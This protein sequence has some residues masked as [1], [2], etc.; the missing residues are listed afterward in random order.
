MCLSCD[1]NLFKILVIN[2][3]ATWIVIFV[4]VFELI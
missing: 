4:K 3:R 2:F 1:F